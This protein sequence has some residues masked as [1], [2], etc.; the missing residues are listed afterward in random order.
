MLWATKAPKGSKDKYTFHYKEMR[1]ENGGKQMKTVWRIPIAGRDEKTFGK[2]PTQKPLALVDR[3]LRAST[4]PGELIVDPFAGSGVTAVAAMRLGR[5]FMVCERD[6][7]YVD[8]IRSRLNAETTNSEQQFGTSEI[9]HKENLQV[10]LL[11][12]SR[13]YRVSKELAAAD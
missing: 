6:S 10:R 2:H 12:K 3:C 9:S 5:I 1:E 8:L 13:P 4:N 11:Q 7:E